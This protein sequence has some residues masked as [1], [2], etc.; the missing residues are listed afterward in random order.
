MNIL[1][2]N[3]F[4][5]PETGGATVYVRAVVRELIAVGH[6]VAIIHGEEGARKIPRVSAFRAFPGLLG[7]NAVPAL[8]TAFKEAVGRMA[9]DLVYIHQVLNPRINEFL[10]RHYPCV[11]F[12]H[13]LRLSCPSG[14][15]MGRADP[16]LCP[17]A[18][19]LLC[20]LRAWSLLC[21]PRNP[22]K[23]RR[24]IMD[25][26]RNIRA[27]KRMA[28]IVVASG[29]V[30][31]LLLR[32][33][34]QADRIAV[35][36]YFTDSP[37]TT[38]RT[39]TWVHPEILFVG[40]LVPEKGVDALIRAL[41]LIKRPLSLRVA[42]DGP[43]LDSIRRLE[44]ESEWPH[45]VFY[46]GWVDSAGLDR[47]YRQAALVVLPSLWPEPFGI[48]GIEAMARGVPVVG[49]DTGGVGE[50]L[51]NGVTGLLVPRGD[52][53]ALAAGIEALAFDPVRNRAMGEAARERFQARFTAERHMERLLK[54]FEKAVG[55]PV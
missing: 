9:P 41:R 2:I 22:V 40:R 33:G 23:A 51:E 48:N 10:A 14:R 19:G 3:E 12:E 4:L 43:A 50:W 7:L 46:D 24:A 13:G 39:V 34:F 17:Y 5:S 45:S 37:K 18:G 11:R 16:R 44:R 55:K 42:G 21:L 36:P 35:I 54:V 49:F 31:D 28:G 53:I 38:D 29:Y 26:R 25:F 27:H 47:L 52:E 15:R 1:V 8:F 30:R 20:G 32:Q 6:S